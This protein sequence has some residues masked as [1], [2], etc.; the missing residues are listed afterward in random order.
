[1]NDTCPSR[2]SLVSPP[3]TAADG[4]PLSYA[5]AAKRALIKTTKSP[6]T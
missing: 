3:T 4:L 6:P 2:S 5:D 1:M